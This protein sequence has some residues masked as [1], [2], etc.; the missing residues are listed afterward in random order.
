MAKKTLRRGDGFKHQNPEYKDEVKA[1]QQEL[2]ALGYSVDVD[3]LF[4]QG[5]E[6][7]IKAFQKKHGSDA[8]GIVGKNTWKAIKGTETTKTVQDASLELKDFRG[9]LKWVHDREGHAGKVYWPGG[10]SGVTLDPG[11]DLG[12]ASPDLIKNAYQ[13]LLTSE[14]MTA[15]QKVMGIKGDDAEKALKADAILK[16]IKINRDQADTIFQYAAIPYWDGIVDRFNTLPETDTLSSVHTVMLSLS[17]N[18]GAKNR[19]LEV[20]KTPLE[21]K[22][23]HELAD[24]IGNMQQDHKLKGIRKRRRMEADLIRKELA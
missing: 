3:G 10:A 2:I 11:V 15:V 19:G 13:D 22:N 4:G 23:W 5:T 20:L 18:R 12:Y 17:Y 7:A 6:D 8:D 21:T 16:E 24:V 14:Q 9:D 1:L